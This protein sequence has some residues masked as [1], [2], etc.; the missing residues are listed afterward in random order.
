MRSGHVLIRS[1]II[2]ISSLSIKVRVKLQ[3]RRTVGECFRDSGA[4]V[5]LNHIL[6][7]QHGRS[8][9]G[10]SPSDVFTHGRNP[11]K[12]LA[13]GKGFFARSG[14]KEAGARNR[15]PMNKKVI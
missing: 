6:Y 1:G 7:A 2:S 11:W 9:E 14:L 4:V 8:L 3:A 13:E 12:I 5:S 10:V 15:E